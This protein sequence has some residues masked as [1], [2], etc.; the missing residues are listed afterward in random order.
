MATAIVSVGLHLTGFEVASWI[1]L[2][3]ATAVW[4]RLAA[5]FVL[6]PLWKRPW[7][8][9]ETAVPAALSAL[10]ATT[11]LG[12][13][14]A[15]LGWHTLAGAMLVAAV[16]TWPGL[17]FAV[18]RHWRSRLPGGA[19]LI[20]VATQ[21]V[22]VLA[23]T[24][25]RAGM[26]DWLT[27]VA[28]VFFGL[29]LVLYVAAFLRFELQQVWTGPGDQWVAT[30]ALAMSALAAAELVADNQWSGPTHD[31]LRVAALAAL[32]LNLLVYVI[33]M[34]AEVIRPRPGYDIRR[35]ATV[36]P[37]GMT[38]VA[39]LSV[40]SATDIPG[41]TTLGNL[42]LLVAVGAW[43]FTLAVLLTNQTTFEADPA[44]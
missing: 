26:G 43:A 12:T 30:G 22:A 8:E 31:T 2:G 29:G 32:G 42:L 23:G 10:A 13:R 33:L 6:R 28:L 15:L 35:W 21:G 16:L 25:A 17:L 18:L 20:C 44:G 11:V 34:V 37:L 9:S 3:L 7:R 38:A 5:D 24:V 1:A 4:I 40:S 19:F 27:I 39:T 36:F 14:M 41:L